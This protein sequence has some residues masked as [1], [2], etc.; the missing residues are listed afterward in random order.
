M[1]KTQEN[2][3][4][5]KKVI[6]KALKKS[7]VFWFYMIEIYYCGKETYEQR[8]CLSVRPSV[9][10][11]GKQKCHEKKQWRTAHKT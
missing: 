8:K 2:R 1:E 7:L 9:S 11:C 5:V 4:Q 6:Q 3:E 10:L